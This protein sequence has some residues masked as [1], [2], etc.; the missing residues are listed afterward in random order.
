[1]AAVRMG[2]DV[3]K[4]TSVYANM[5]LALRIPLSGIREQLWLVPKAH[6]EA[7]RSSLMRRFTGT[8]ALVRR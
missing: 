1:M 3:R 4:A 2:R 6:E 7:V 8:A 5:R